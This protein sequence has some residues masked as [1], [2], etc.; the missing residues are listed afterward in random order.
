MSIYALQDES[1]SRDGSH[2]LTRIGRLGI[3]ENLAFFYQWRDLWEA[4]SRSVTGGA[5]PLEDTFTRLSVLWKEHAASLSDP[6][7]I[8]SA[9][10]YR[11]L[12]SLGPEIVPLILD[13]LRSDPFHWFD[14]LT[15][16]TGEVPFPAD[17]A[18][19]VPKM[20]SAWRGWAKERQI[21]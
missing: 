4:F 8:K 16:I 5:E 14:V 2:R 3:A 7:D 18:G 21:A 1:P 6:A 17:D 12:V 10:G 15:D 20:V 19:D 13:E 11:E 9:P